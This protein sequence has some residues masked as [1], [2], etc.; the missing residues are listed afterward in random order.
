[1]LTQRNIY[2]KE[3]RPKPVN[4]VILDGLLETG[5]LSSKI[6]AFPSS[7]GVR[8]LAPLHKV[9]ELVV[10]AHFV[11]VEDPLYLNK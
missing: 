6:V 11:V 9:V 2:K 3:Q 4:P 10:F 8:K 7:V 5:H 1:M